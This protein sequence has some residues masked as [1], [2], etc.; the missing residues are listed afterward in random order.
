MSPPRPAISAAL[1]RLGVAP[2]ALGRVEINEAFASVAL[3]L[4]EAVR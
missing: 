2:S 3:A 1:H 4:L